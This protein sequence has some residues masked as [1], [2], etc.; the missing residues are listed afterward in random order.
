MS[1]IE[2]RTAASTDDCT[3]YWNGSTWVMSTND[4]DAHCVGYYS[5]AIAKQGTGE[6]YLNI[7]IPPG[8]T[9]NAA[10]IQFRC[11]PTYPKSGTTVNCRIIGDDE[12]DAATFSD[13]AN[14]QSRRGTSVGGANN[15]KRTTAYVDWDNLAAWSVGNDYQSPDI[16]TVIQEI[17][18]R[19]GWQ[20]GNAIALFWDDHDDRSSHGSDIRRAAVS[21][22]KDTAT[23]PLLHI[24]YTEPYQ[25]LVATLVTQ[26]I[27]IGTPD[28]ER[29]LRVL[30]ASLVTQTISIGSA[31]IERLLRILE[32]SLVTQSMTAYSA[33]ISLVQ[34]WQRMVTLR[35]ALTGKAGKF[36]IVN[37][38]E[39]GFTFSE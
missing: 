31:E 30:E 26:T 7:T 27:S 10:Y 38:D 34:H 12:D 13:L 4:G 6:R 11:N 18:D 5:A 19:P 21:Y 36:L 25:E 29:M 2:K 17:I 22:D 9:I 3:C 35:E 1:T 14:Y 37:D 33:D 28:I 24:E 20:S 8:S 16:K 23:A 32:A 39:N 15:D